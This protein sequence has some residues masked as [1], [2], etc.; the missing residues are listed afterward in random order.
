MNTLHLSRRI[1]L[2]MKNACYLC[3][4]RPSA[5]MC[6]PGSHLMGFHEILYLRLSLKSVEKHKIWLQ[7]D[8]NIRNFTWRPTTV[9]CCWRQKHSLW[10]KWYETVRISEEVYT[11]H[12]QTTILYCRYIAGHFFFILISCFVYKLFVKPVQISMGNCCDCQHHVVLTV[13]QSIAL[14]SQILYVLCIWMYIKCFCWCVLCWFLW[15]MCFEETSFPVSLHLCMHHW[16][17][18]DDIEEINFVKPVTFIWFCLQKYKDSAMT[19]VVSRW[20]V[21][22]RPKFIPRPVC[23]RFV[24][25]KVTMGQGFLRV[26]WFPL[27]VSFPWCSVLFHSAVIEG[28]KIDNKQIIMKHNFIK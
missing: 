23:V 16:K 11:L 22:T 14:N 24:V 28:N 12:E 25:I 13:T 4:V 17:I 19:Q 10:V 6:Q 20:P 5:C 2:L 1:C 27:S 7:Y 3:H 21:T 18:L 8:T 9:Y 15:Y 26:L